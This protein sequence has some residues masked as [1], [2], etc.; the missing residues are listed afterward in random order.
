MTRLAR[1]LVRTTCVLMAFAISGPA[2]EF[3]LNPIVRHLPSFL[4][5][6]VAP[7]ALLDFLDYAF[8]KPACVL[9]AVCVLL[10]L[11]SKSITWWAKIALTLS[12]AVTCYITPPWVEKVKH[13]W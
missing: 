5:L 11:L 4:G 12:A 13:M 1:I 8:G 2:M 9:L 10:V 7:F 3:A 6:L